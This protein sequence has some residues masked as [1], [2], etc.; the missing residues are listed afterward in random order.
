MSTGQVF[1][2]GLLTGMVGFTFVG[3]WVE[4]RLAARRARNARIIRAARQ[5]GRVAR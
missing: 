5:D 2:A 3:G 1:G 4:Q